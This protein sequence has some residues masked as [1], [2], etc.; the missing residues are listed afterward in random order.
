MPRWHPCAASLWAS[1][2]GG[3]ALARPAPPEA[4]EASGAWESAAAAFHAASPSRPVCT[5]R[6]GE[7]LAKARER[8]AAL[9]PAGQRAVARAQGRALDDA[10]DAWI[11]RLLERTCSTLRNGMPRSEASLGRCLDAIP[12]ELAHPFWADHLTPEPPWDE[13]FRRAGRCPRDRVEQLLRE[14]K[15]PEARSMASRCTGDDAEDVAAHLRRSCDD[16]AGRAL[17]AGAP[18][19][20]LGAV[21]A[22]GTCSEE[23]VGRVREAN[24]AEQQA[25]DASA[26]CEADVADLLANER[27]AE[28][29]ARA[30]SPG[31]PPGLSDHAQVQRWRSETGARCAGLAAGLRR[32]PFAVDWGRAGSD[33]AGNDPAC[34]AARAEVDDLFAAAVKD[35]LARDP[36]EL[37]RRS[38]ALVG[39]GSVPTLER[40]AAPEARRAAATACGGQVRGLLAARRF[41][42]ALAD[43][44]ALVASRIDGVDLPVLADMVA[45]L[46]ATGG[47]P[48]Y[49]T[50]SAVQHAIAASELPA[51]CTFARGLHL[52][53][54]RDG[55]YP[56]GPYGSELQGFTSP[57]LEVGR[58]VSGVSSFTRVVVRSELESDAETLVADVLP[59]WTETRVDVQGTARGL[60][61]V[62][63]TIE[64]PGGGGATVQVQQLRRHLTFV[65]P[66]GLAPVEVVVPDST[67]EQHAAREAWPDVRRRWNAALAVRARARLASAVDLADRLD[68]AVELLLFEPSDTAARSIVEA[69]VA[70]GP[71]E[72]W[73]W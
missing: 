34:E 4:T 21:D 65:P 29:L 49:P 42:E 9:D 70:L 26:G 8:F 72:R 11:A 30:G 33:L 57:N 2:L 37:T 28:A 36:C 47:P 19:D 67:D 41:D 38:T 71:G 13:V 73:P 1:L 24:D 58:D 62:R 69:N 22:Y 55:G 60:V 23:M 16:A 6:L 5:V 46:P 53:L 50:R 15:I 44:G 63:E 45:A 43:H 18:E 54:A 40:L 39:Y 51:R 32:D 14:G 68:A 35:L 17:H 59:G 66:P 10:M 52:R 27:F 3:P 25:A 61:S 56:W 31:C 12:F 48:V 20:A 64:H 7:S